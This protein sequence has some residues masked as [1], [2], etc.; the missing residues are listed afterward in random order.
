MKVGIVGLPNA[1]KST[2]FN[3]LTSGGAQTGDYPFTTIE[4]N[5]AV[6]RV[7]DERLE[8][9][10]ETVRS[11]ELVPATIDFHDIAGLVKGASEGE[12]LGNQFLASIRETDAICHVVRCHSL[13]S[14]VPH[15]DG[16]VD[17]LADIETIET[18]LVLADFEQVE[19][20]LNRVGKGA[21]SGDPEAIAEHAW[22]Q[23]V[24]EAL[25]AGRPARSVPLPAAAPDAARN[26]QALTSKPILY[27]ANVDEGDSEPPEA[28][29]SH[30]AA[31]GAG[32]VAV[33]A[34]IE[35]ELAEL[36]PAEAEEMRESYGVE[37]SGLA[38]LVRAAYDLLELIT[39]F[40]AGEDK[41]AVARP[42]HRGATALEAAG[43]IHT[44]IMEAFVKAE[45]IGWQQLVET[46]GYVAARDRG[47]LRI[48]G[49]DYPVADGD[50][51]TI[52]V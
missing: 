35:G 10:A 2:L 38:R 1:G 3:A 18:E 49:R 6:A 42:L 7:P 45:V 36:D 17:P 15:P 14:G 31:V 21:K 41:E 34:R 9:V 39:F 47:L 20:R 37:G 16:R 30:A 50:V 48:E 52:K 4:P 19:R 22:L 43:T 33:S 13:D 12:G 51:I 11:S 29:S 32:V 28:V 40:T 25:A 24:R 26:L 44:E 27:V 23:A 5:V 46:G 8:A